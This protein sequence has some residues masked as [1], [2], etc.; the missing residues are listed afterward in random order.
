MIPELRYFI[1]RRYQEEK[2]GEEQIHSDEQLQELI[3]DLYLEI[4]RYFDNRP[5]ET[6]QFKEWVYNM[7]DRFILQYMKREEEQAD[8]TIDELTRRETEGFDE[9][10]AWDAEGERY[11][12][13][14]FADPAD[15]LNTYRFNDF[16]PDEVL[17]D[18]YAIEDY[19]Q[20][21]EEFNDK[22][23]AD[24]ARFPIEKRTTFDYYFN[25]G[26]SPEEISR[27]RNV[28]VQEVK[29]TLKDI[30]EYL[31]GDLREWLT[32]QYLTM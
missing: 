15:V 5:T 9:T 19:N 16:F 22:V 3:D 12:E 23:I 17:F 20:F 7:A 25:E 10:F 31:R 6:D 30:V 29:R 14:E 26:F 13:E 21:V 2:R 32:R 1:E 4:W 18:Q 8:V 27:I 11:L 24:L 28:P